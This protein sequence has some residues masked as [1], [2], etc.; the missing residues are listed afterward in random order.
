MDT[1]TSSFDFSNKN[2]NEHYTYRNYFKKFKQYLANTFQK[3]FK[4]KKKYVKEP[5]I[6]KN[7][8]NTKKI[9]NKRSKLICLVHTCIFFIS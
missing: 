3:I 1:T 4:T 7:A 8:S 5:E 9:K 2:K 6:V